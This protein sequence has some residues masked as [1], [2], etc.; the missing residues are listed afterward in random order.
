MTRVGLVTKP[1]ATAES[2]RVVLTLLDW[3]AA[4]GLTPVLEKVLPAI[5]NVLASRCEV[6][7]LVKPQFEVGKKDVG[8]GG[9]VRDPALHR[10]S[11]QRLARFSVLRGWHVLGVT[12]SPIRGAKGNREFFLHL[13]TQGRTAND[14]EG[15][16]MRTVE[17]TA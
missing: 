3:L 13:S 5:F 9:I 8:K 15:M 17:A 2:Q 6:L 11:V 7:A 1:D 16:I 12:S 14:L 4:H 10:S